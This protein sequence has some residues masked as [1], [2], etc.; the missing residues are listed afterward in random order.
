M[1][2]FWEETIGKTLEQIMYVGSTSLVVNYVAMSSL[3]NQYNYICHRS[4]KG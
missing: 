3:Q 4:L 2:N 1:V